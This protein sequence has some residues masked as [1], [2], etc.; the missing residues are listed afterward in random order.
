MLGDGVVDPV[1]ATLMQAVEEPAGVTALT[2]A[3]EDV[4]TAA[5]ND[6]VQLLGSVV[7]IPV[8]GASP[9][10]RSRRSP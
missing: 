1:V 7:P 6:V 9:P 10:T 3:A 8:E 4:G 2:T 5:A